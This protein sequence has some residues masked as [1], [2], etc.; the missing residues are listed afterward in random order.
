MQ[1]NKVKQKNSAVEKAIFNENGAVKV[2]HTE[3]KSNENT[4]K[5]QG[6]KRGLLI[7]VAFLVTALTAVTA[8]F[9]AS[10]L[11]TV[12]LERELDA[13]YKRAYIG[14]VESVENIELNMAKFSAS[15][16]YANG[17]KYL[18]DIAI[19]AEKAEN[20][21]QELPLRDESKF[22]TAKLVNQVGDFSK[23]L[24]N[25]IALG[26]DLSNE[27][28]DNFIVL[29]NA[30]IRLK[31]TLNNSSVD[32]INFSSSKG[33]SKIVAGFDELENLS[34]SF[35]ELIY[36]G[37]FSDGRE[38]REIKFD[39]GEKL[40]EVEAK[41][42]LIKS[43]DSLGV[44][45]LNYLGKTAG[46]INGYAFSTDASIG[47][48]YA[49]V[50]EQGGRLLLLTVSSNSTKSS[51]NVEID[52]EKTA[53]EFCLGAGIESPMPVWK[54]E[55]EDFITLNLAYSIGDIPIYSDLVKV[56]ISKSDGN[57]VGFEAFDYYINHTSRN[58]ENAS[59]TESQARQK[60]SKSLQVE[61]SR[62]AVIPVGET[63]EELCYEFVCRENNETFYVYIS[64]T[65]LKEMKIFRVVKGTEGEFLM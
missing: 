25:K 21:L 60:V 53:I 3:Q 40:T 45:S 31:Q 44:K 12:A 8:F 57:V 9:T 43:L 58:L 27:D 56:K 15:N 7:L 62:L 47:N 38:S 22:S 59:K 61:K 35:P 5:K 39:L 36:D 65:T 37:P 28:K 14:T 29:K 10:Q 64:A 33:L 24:S 23:Y 46:K 1:E 51:E 20:D 63:A 19:N 4:T 6:K 34:V 26:Q 52:A 30:I 2:D 48:L 16:D 13:V 11:K 41:E 50:S 49:Q 42:K 55:T 54:I 17:Q 18:T 32:E